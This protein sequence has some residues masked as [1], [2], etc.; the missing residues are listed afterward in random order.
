MQR[1]AAEI[2]AS[3]SRRTHDDERNEIDAPGS[4]AALT[5]GRSLVRVADISR[6]GARIETYTRLERGAE[7]TLFIPGA[8]PL[9]GRIAWAGDFA[10][11]LAF[12]KPLDEA[13]LDDLVANYGFGTDPVVQSRS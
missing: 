8:A 11:G 5:G 9:P 7:L 3:A 13:T 2:A 4:L 10:A 1:I 12:L 6:R